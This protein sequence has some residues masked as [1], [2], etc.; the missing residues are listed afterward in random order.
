M[1][2]VIKFSAAWCAPC[3]S[4]KPMFEKFAE[5]VKDSDVEVLDLDVDE[6][7]DE[8]S[9]YGVQSIPFT[10]F[11]KE[12]KIAKSFKGVVPTNKLLDTFKEVY[13]G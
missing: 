10:V 12:D 2:K 3:K 7:P 9:S 13:G 4:M 1:N 6:N 8:A 5:D 11:V